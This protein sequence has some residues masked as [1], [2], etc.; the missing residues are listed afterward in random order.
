MNKLRL[1]TS[2][3]SANNISCISLNINNDPVSNQAL[4]D[5]TMRGKSS[6]MPDQSFDIVAGQSVRKNSTVRNR[7]SGA[8]NNPNASGSMSSILAQQ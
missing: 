5:T 2:A 4:V 1:N 6:I 8:M 3:F 7:Q